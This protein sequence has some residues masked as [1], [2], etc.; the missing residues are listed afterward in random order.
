MI[1]P[2]SSEFGTSAFGASNWITSILNAR[3]QEL[4]S[5]FSMLL[6]QACPQHAHSL[7]LPSPEALLSDVQMQ[8]APPTFQNQ[9]A[10]VNDAP[11]IQSSSKMAYQPWIQQMSDKYNVPVK[12]I[13]SVIQA[14]SNFNPSVTSHAGAMGMMQLMPATAKW[15]GVQNPYNA[16]ENIEGGVKYLGQMLKKYNGDL[17]KSVAAYNAGPGNVDRY[18]GIPPFRETQDYVRKVLGTQFV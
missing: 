4:L 1:N 3:T 12:L 10:F 15:L 13:N 16:T 7:Q 5:T 18:G 9:T 14:E 8:A 17:V 2:T 11:A 6:E